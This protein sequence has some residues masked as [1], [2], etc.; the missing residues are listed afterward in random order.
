MTDHRIMQ[1]E[2][3]LFVYYYLKIKYKQQKIEQIEEQ[4]SASC[5]K[6]IGMRTPC[7]SITCVNTYSLRCRLGVTVATFW[8][9][10]HALIK[11]RQRYHVLFID[12]MFHV[13]LQ[14]WVLI[15]YNG[16]REK[17]FWITNL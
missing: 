15:I 10:G 3:L 2:K 5:K 7:L 11:V 14:Q 12:K 4:F 6:N 13:H 17:G 1:L 9:V 8:H 16:H